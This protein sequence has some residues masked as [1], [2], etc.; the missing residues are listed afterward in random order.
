MN[1][2]IHVLILILLLIGSI[3]IGYD[4]T[5]YYFEIEL[6][7]LMVFVLVLAYLPP[8]LFLQFVPAK[9]PNLKCKRL[10]AYSVDLLPGY[11]PRT[12]SCSKCG[13]VYYLYNFKIHNKKT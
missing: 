11:A 1:I 4:L 12:F 3:F 2:F 10:S 8:M 5:E 13:S 9:C 7:W 6:P